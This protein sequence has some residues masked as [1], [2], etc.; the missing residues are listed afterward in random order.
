MLLNKSVKNVLQSEKEPGSHLR[1]K[2]ANKSPD[3]CEWV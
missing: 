3:F 1:S 2:N